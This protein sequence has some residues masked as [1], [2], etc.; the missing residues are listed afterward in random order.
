MNK[1]RKF[2]SDLKLYSDYLGY[3]DDVGRYETWE[4]AV[5]NVLD[6]HRQ[7][8]SHVVKELEPYLKYAG[9][10]YK[11]RRFL[12]SQRMLQ[13]RGED[14]FKHEFRGY[15]CLVTYADKPS[16]L[17]NAFYLLLCGCGVGVN[18]MTPFVSR[19]PAVQS[20]TKGTKTH[21]VEDSI[22]G[23]AEAAH[24]LV[25]SYLAYGSSEKFRQYNGYV[26]KFD[27]SL[28]RPKGSKVGRRFKAPGPDGLQKSFEA[29]ETLMNSYVEDFEKPFK[30]IIAYDIFMHLSDAVLSGG[31]RRSASSIIISPE[32]EE[33]INAKTGNWREKHRQRERSNNS[34]GLLKHQFTKEEFRAFLEMTQGQS[35]IGFVFLNNIFEI[36]NPCFEISFVPLLFDYSREDIKLRI[37]Q[38]DITLLDEGLVS[39]GIQCC[40]LNEGNGQMCKTK[41]DLFRMVRA[42]AILG[43]CQ[44]GFTNFKHLED[45]LEE[46]IAISE[47]ESLLGVS[48]S[49]WCNQPWLFDA[50]VLEEAVKIVKATNEEVAAILGIRPAAR[51]TTVKPSGNSA[52]VLG[53]AS[54]IHPEHSKRYFRVMQLNKDTETAI[55]LKENMPII[56][57]DGVYSST[58]SD[59]AAF[60]PIENEDG[61]L[62]KNDLQ[63]ISHLEK[64]RLVKKH[65]VNPGTVDERAICPGTSHNVS[66]TVIIDDRDAITEYLFEH[67]DDFTA[68]SFISLY[69]DKDYNQTPNT[70]VL[71]FEEITALYGKGSLFAS[72]IIVDGLH[73]FNGNLWDACEH[74]LYN[75]TP[76]GT[77]DQVL[78]RSSWIK[79]AKKFAKNYFKGNLEKMIYCLKDVHL[80]HKWETIKRE[81]KE[82]DF[83]EILKEPQYIE[84]D[85]MGAQACSGGACEI[86][87]LGK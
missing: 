49:G 29:I 66:N 37:Q 48:I 56:L 21:V 12:G 75:K 55:W 39:T 9:D 16:F 33:L 26:I 65:W 31:V 57:E 20:R 58:E 13:F 38:S 87:T 7:K 4:E 45:C 82:V 84:L 8:Y 73:Y 2:L 63:G 27:Y 14:I 50:E 85:T 19:L 59:F 53:C 22:E 67:Q 30:S 1:E 17:G 35:D 10:A 81:M 5:D 41:D 72:G 62:Y 36:L 52:V 76:Y 68:V 28:V 6:T 43:T 42:E 24:I 32:D 23:W 74:V 86:V 51:L 44:A 25:N 79:R 69:G 11:E 47:Y 83:T 70:S 80:C 64:I 46:T 54:G 60:V 15:N 18:M 71:T 77:R 78:L 3:R 61:T 40:N 34:V